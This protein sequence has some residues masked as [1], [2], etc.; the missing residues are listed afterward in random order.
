MTDTKPFEAVLQNY[1]QK[2]DKLGR[3]I[4][5]VK[6]LHSGC[7]SYIYNEDVYRVYFLKQL[8]EILGKLEH[9]YDTDIISKSESTIEF[10]SEKYEFEICGILR[11]N[12][13]EQVLLMN[14]WPPL[15]EKDDPS[16]IHKFDRDLLKHSIKKFAEYMLLYECPFGIL[17]VRENLYFVEFDQKDFEENCKMGK[18]EECLRIKLYSASA[19]DINPSLIEVLLSWVLKYLKDTDLKQNMKMLKETYFANRLDKSNNILHDL[20]MNNLVPISSEE[21][22]GLEEI[23]KRNVPVIEIKYKEY[24]LMNCGNNECPSFKVRASKIPFLEPNLNP[25]D[26]VVI[27]VYDHKQHESYWQQHTKTS[28]R[29]YNEHTERKLLWL[30]KASQDPEFNS[31]LIYNKEAIAHVVSPLGLISGKCILRKHIETVPMP[32]DEETYRKVKHQLKVLRR[33]G[34]YYSLVF[35]KNAIYSRDGKVFILDF[36]ELRDDLDLEDQVKSEKR[37]LSRLFGEEPFFED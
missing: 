23:E 28:Y 7:A 21:V 15:K 18:T 6:S 30:S 35:C 2:N 5:Q 31:C 19:S 36:S 20:V 1:L 34:L 24:S 26:Q 17:M 16:H 37:L 3:V 14:K 32:K 8:I 9:L 29:S 27:T 12:K 33:N 25:Q 4:K 10:D 22:K 13:L 11:V